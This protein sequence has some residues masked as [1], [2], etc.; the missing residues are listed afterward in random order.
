[1]KTSLPSQLVSESMLQKGP[2]GQSLKIVMPLSRTRNPSTLG[3]D[4]GRS[5]RFKAGL[6]YIASSKSAGA[7]Y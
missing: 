6:I 4:T 2:E 3:A 5:L 1:M 7:K